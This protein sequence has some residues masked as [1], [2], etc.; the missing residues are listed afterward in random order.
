MSTVRHRWIASRLAEAFGV[1]VAVAQAFLDRR[2]VA[3]EL[4]SFLNGSGPL[5]LFVF[6]QP[7]DVAGAVRLKSVELSVRACVDC[8]APGLQD[9]TLGPGRGPNELILSSGDSLPL[10]GSAMWLLRNTDSAAVDLTKVRHQDFTFLGVALPRLWLVWGTTSF[11]CCM[12]MKSVRRFR[13]VNR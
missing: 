6:Y 9:G 7:R 3:P 8:R 1:D 10:R 12:F 5:C 2:D 4:T 11:H 13:A